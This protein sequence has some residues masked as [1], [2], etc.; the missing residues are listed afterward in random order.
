[1]GAE[2]RLTENFS[3]A[4]CR[5]KVAKVRLTPL[6]ANGLRE[7]LSEGGNLKYYLVTC[8]L[9]GYTE[10]YDSRVFAVWTENLPQEQTV[11]QKS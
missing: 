2:S 9:C 11:P 5:S 7:F 4:K 6:P 1:M 8:T 3:C 10:M